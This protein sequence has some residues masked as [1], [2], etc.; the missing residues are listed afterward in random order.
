M[1]HISAFK[2]K[3]VKPN[4]KLFEKTCE[5]LA[6]RF[7]A[8]RVKHFQDW[9]GHKVEPLGIVLKLP[10]KGAQ[11]PFVDIYI[12]NQGFVQI[13]GDQMG[14]RDL[15]IDKLTEAFSEIYTAL[16]YQQALATLGFQVNVAEQKNGGY[17]IQGVRS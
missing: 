4:Q 1:S 11:V 13:R 3:I 8:E 14:L 12:D 2:T 7:N 17:I 6:K 15:P 10:L 16:G 5:L 9:Y